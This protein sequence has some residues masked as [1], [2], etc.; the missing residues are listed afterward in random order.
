[1]DTGTMKRCPRCGEVKSRDLFGKSGGG[2]CGPCMTQYVREY[3]QKEQAKDPDYLDRVAAS[4]HGLTLIEYRTLMRMPCWICGQA[5][6]PGG[7]RSLHWQKPTIDHDHDC[8]NQRNGSCGR[9][10]RGMLCQNCN[11]GVARF[12]DNPD[13]L[14]AAADYL[15]REPIVFGELIA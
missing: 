3:R 7:G 14:R 13:L 4:R 9:C 8:C 11:T 15:E 12:K 10:V 2:Y 6:S 5:C 1:M